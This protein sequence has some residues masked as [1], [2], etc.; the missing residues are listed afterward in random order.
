MMNAVTLIMQ[1]E[2]AICFEWKIRGGFKACPSWVQALGPREAM[3]LLVTRTGPTFW[4]AFLH[5]FAA[6][7]IKSSTPREVDRL[8]EA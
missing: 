7:R 4:R 2:K 6:A 3:G 1:F 8:R 5:N